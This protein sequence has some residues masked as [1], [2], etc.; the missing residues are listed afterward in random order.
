[1][2]TLYRKNSLGIGV[3]HVEGR[4]LTETTGHLLIQHSSVLGGALISHVNPVTTNNSGR[5]IGQQLYLEMTARISRQKDKGYKE[6]VAEAELG[7]TN[8]IGLINPMLALKIADVWLIQQH[9]DGGAFVQF[10]Y[11]GH[12]GLITKQGGEMLAYTRRG[13]PITTIPHVLE[14]FEPILQDGD[15]VDGELYIHGVPLQGLSSLIKRQ[16]P[17]SRRLCYRW[18]DMVSDQPY[19]ERYRLMREL[20]ENFDHPQVGLVETKQVSRMAEVY[21]HFRIARSLGYEGSMLRL[22]L[23]GYEG[24]KRSDQ[25]LKVKEREDCEVTTVGVRPSVNNWAILRVRMDSGVEFDISAPGSVPEKTEVLQNY[26]AKYH[27]RRL[28]IEYANL[29]NDGVPFHAVA[30]RWHEEL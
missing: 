8:Q 25:L 29:T 23:R 15:T 26:E 1:M 22:S 9:F 12:R 30:M 21:E 11:D 2:T 18:Y 6:T 14:A 19:A 28:T 24:A 17:D 5:S 3:W 13:K 4:Q 7:S 27:N 10:K 16:Q 20:A